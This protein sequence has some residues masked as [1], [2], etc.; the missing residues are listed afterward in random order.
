MTDVI[1]HQDN[2]SGTPGPVPTAVGEL[3]PERTYGTFAG[4]ASLYVAG[5]GLAL[6]A[7]HAVGIPTP[8]CPLRWSTGFP[9]PFCGLTHVARALLTG[10]AGVVLGNDPAGLVLAVILAV[11][12]LSQIL[13][14]V[15]RT[16]GPALLRSRTAGIVAAVV[17]AAHWGTTIVTGGMLTA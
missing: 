10:H 17:L 3:H 2:T 11:A 7:V 8:P 6:V 5:T 14:M 4:R 9:C 13:S 1:H 12:V 15:R 16:T